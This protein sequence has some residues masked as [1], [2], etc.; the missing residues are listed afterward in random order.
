MSSPS[1][2]VTA[3]VDA[4]AL[5]TA[6]LETELLGYLKLAALGYGLWWAWKHRAKIA[7][8]AHRFFK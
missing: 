1:D 6:T 3:A 5:P 4:Y 7:A 2:A 8:Q